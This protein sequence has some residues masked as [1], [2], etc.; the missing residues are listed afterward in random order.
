MTGD[1]RKELNPL[2]SGLGYVL[3]T[4][5][6]TFVKIPTKPSGASYQQPLSDMV[7]VMRFLASFAPSAN[8]CFS[9]GYVLKTFRSIFVKIPTKPSS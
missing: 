9:F 2:I 8:T 6:S 4:F 7:L 3:Q 5:R 1:Q